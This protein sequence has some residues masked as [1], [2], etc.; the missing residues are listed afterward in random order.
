MERPATRMGG[1]DRSMRVA[2][3]FPT[4]S[5]RHKGSLRAKRSNLGLLDCHADRGSARN[6]GLPYKKH[7]QNHK[8]RNRY[9]LVTPFP[10]SAFY[11]LLIFKKLVKQSNDSNMGLYAVPDNMGSV[12]YLLTT[13]KEV[14]NA[15]HSAIYQ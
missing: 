15:E 1:R 3:P 9:V 14:R 10:E 13:E 4:T 2:R 8:K 12:D 5:K 11:S 7:P 6:D